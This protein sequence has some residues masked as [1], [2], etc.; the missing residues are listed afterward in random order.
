MSSISKG[1]GVAKNDMQLSITQTAKAQPAP[2]KS[3]YGIATINV[4]STAI[5]REKPPTDPQTRSDFCFDNLLSFLPHDE[6]KLLDVYRALNVPSKTLRKW[7]SKGKKKL[8]EYV[9]A[10]LKQQRNTA[11]SEYRFAMDHLYVWGLE[12]DH[13]VWAMAGQEKQ[14][15]SNAGYEG[16]AGRV[17]TSAV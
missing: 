11:P 10:T 17:F 8:G 13:D 14:F 1:K 6:Y 4:L 5:S 12:N 16:A 3:A 2:G 7:A 15:D 9:I